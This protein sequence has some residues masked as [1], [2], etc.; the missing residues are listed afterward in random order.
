MDP[1]AKNYLAAAVSEHLH[2][3]LLI[4]SF[5]MY[6]EQTSCKKQT[7]KTVL[8]PEACSQR[9]IESTTGTA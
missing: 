7:I 3:P 6:M 9:H 4:P 5:G 2:K 8:H 1:V